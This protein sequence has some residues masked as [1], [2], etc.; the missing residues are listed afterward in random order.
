MTVSNRYST[1]QLPDG[2]AAAEVQLDARDGR[3]RLGRQEETRTGQLSSSVGIQA[4]EVAR[5]SAG[6]TVLLSLM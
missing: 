3:G 5:T 4:E 1:T 6:P 2:E